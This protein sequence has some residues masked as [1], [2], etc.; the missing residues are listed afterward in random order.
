MSFFTAC[1]AGNHVTLS[2][3][4]LADET[5]VRFHVI[6]D[7]AGMDA[8]TVAKAF[9]PFFSGREAGRQCGLGLSKAYRFVEANGGAIIL[10]STPE[11]G[12]DAWITFPPAPPKDTSETEVNR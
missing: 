6:D 5:L 12:T 1:E 4:H 11:R 2:V 7:G 3:E 8:E 9:N 10:N